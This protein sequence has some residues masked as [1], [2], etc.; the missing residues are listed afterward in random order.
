MW[1][2]KLSIA[3]LLKCA[4]HFSC[5]SYGWVMMKEGEGCTEVEV[6]SEAKP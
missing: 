5:F 6:W 1:Y 4:P 3:F 2:V